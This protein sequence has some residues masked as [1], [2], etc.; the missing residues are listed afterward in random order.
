MPVPR[1]AT[2]CTDSSISRRSEIVADYKDI[3]VNVTYDDR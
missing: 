1:V 3:K 2:V